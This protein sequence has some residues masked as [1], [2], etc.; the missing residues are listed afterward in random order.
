MEDKYEKCINQWN[1]IF[2]KSNLSVPTSIS[3][4]NEVLDKGIKWL[5]HGTEK[6]LDFG[7]GNGT[8]LF[9]CALNGTKHHIGIDLSEKGIASAEKRK[10]HMSKGEFTFIC[11]G[12]ESLK[13]IESE[14]IDA[15]VFSNILDNLYPEDAKM[16]I[17]EA[18]RLLRIDGKL[19]VKLNPYITSAQI[20]E[21]NI[22]IIKD[23]LLDDGLV[24]W[25]N[26]T[27]E[28]KSFFE[29]NFEII[30]YEDIYYPEH[31]QYNRMF[32]LCKKQHD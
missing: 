19:L 14:T 20:K 7:C 2:S 16:L 12:I 15:I 30:N 26:T 3:S 9:L 32:W 17:N 6:I 10:S 28:W 18:Y 27:E 11:G 5:C 13:N 24:L 31:N 29:Q 22:K 1:K 8:M 4:G 21:W 23:N 25:N